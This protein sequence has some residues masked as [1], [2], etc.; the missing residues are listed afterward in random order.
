MHRQ[1]TLEK[2]NDYRQANGWLWLDKPE[3]NSSLR[4]REE[5][6]AIATLF[7]EFIKAHDNCFARECQPGHLTG[8]ALVVSPKLDRVLL[9]LH[10]KLN[11]WLQLGGHAD[12]ISDIVEVT[13]TEVQEESGLQVFEF[14]KLQSSSSKILPFD[15]DRHLIPARP[16]EPAHFHYDLRFLVVADDGQQIEISDESHDLKWFNLPD[17]QELTSE[18]SMQRQ[19]DKLAKLANRSQPR[20]L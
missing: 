8:S 11:K 1:Q 3:A 10:K 20:S 17:A 18:L 4:T 14:I 13:E 6:R 2:L 12:G 19:F 7:I 15:L 9:T 5:E 16:D